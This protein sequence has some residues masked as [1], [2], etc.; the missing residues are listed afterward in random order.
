MIY[1]P[2]LTLQASAVPV[3][4]WNRDLK[5]VTETRRATGIAVY[6]C[7]QSLSNDADEC[8]S[9]KFTVSVPIYRMSFAVCD[10]TAQLVGGVNLRSALGLEARFAFN[11]C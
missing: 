10:G 11:Y 7:G 2:L 8:S 6:L 3:I 9:F 1:I 4:P 5:T